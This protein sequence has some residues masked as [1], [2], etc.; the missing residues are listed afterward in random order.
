MRSNKREKITKL[1]DTG[2]R[3]IPILHSQ[4]L[5]YGEHL[6]RYNFAI[7]KSQNKIVLDIACGTGYGSQI[8]ASSAKN[9]IG[10]DL[11]DEA[12]EYAKKNYS[13]KNLIYKQGSAYKIPVDNKSV[14]MV[15]SMETI[16]HLDKPEIFLKEVK[17]VLRSDG[18]FIVSTPNDNEFTDSNIYHIHQFR[19]NELNLMLSKYFSNTNYYYQGSYYLSAIFKKSSFVNKIESN[20]TTS[21]Y[22]SQNTEKAVYFIAVCTNQKTKIDDFSENC[23]ISDIWNENDSIKQSKIIQDR[24]NNLDKALT[25]QTIH[26]T[27]LDKLLERVN[28]ENIA[29]KNSKTYKIAKRLANIKNKIIK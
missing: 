23:V 19:K 21:K 14:D 1:E 18:L 15:V 28:E 4:S 24:I 11:S 5:A 12:I 13:A 17:R 20:I 29:I 6:A 7:Q 25:E 22:F 10:V 27:K 16:E 8:L 2:E 26:A 3:L 9:V